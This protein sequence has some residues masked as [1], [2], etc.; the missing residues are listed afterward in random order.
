MQN[1]LQTE[2]GARATETGRMKASVR[3]WHGGDGKPPVEV[4]GVTAIEDFA[5]GDYIMLVPD[6]YYFAFSNS[7]VKDR[8]GQ[9]FMARAAARI[10]RAIK[11]TKK[12]AGLSIYVGRSRAVENIMNI[13]VNKSKTPRKRLH[14][15]KN[16][17]AG[18][19]G[20]G[21]PV[22]YIKWK[23]NQFQVLGA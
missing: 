3:V 20:I 4:T 9:G 2:I 23:S 6:V 16:P 12:T 19:S 10:R 18:K 5:V 14:P 8:T 17:L 21:V 15:A 13:P 22:I 7:R 1:A 11:V